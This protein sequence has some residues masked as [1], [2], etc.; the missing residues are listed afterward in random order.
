MTLPIHYS[1][2]DYPRRCS[3]CYKTTAELGEGVILIT[4]YYAAICSRCIGECL[5]CLADT[6]FGNDDHRYDGCAW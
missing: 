6:M 4:S 5:H 3:F 2:P 1:H